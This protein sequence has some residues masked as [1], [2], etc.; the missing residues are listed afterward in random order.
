MLTIDMRCP[1]KKCRRRTEN[2]YRMVGQCINCGTK[3]ILMLFREGDPA[4]AGGRCPLC[5]NGRVVAQRLATPDEIP[6][7]KG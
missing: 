6:E 2:I 4:T 3:P 5:G 1:C 7:A